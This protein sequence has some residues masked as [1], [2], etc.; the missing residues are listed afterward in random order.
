[1]S[2]IVPFF[3]VLDE[4]GLN[5]SVLSLELDDGIDLYI[6]HDLYHPFKKQWFRIVAN[7]FVTSTSLYSHPRLILR[8]V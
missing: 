1:M 2:A 8:A 4:A 6:L 3:R 7:R 5:A